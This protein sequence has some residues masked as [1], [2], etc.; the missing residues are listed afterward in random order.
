VRRATGWSLR[1]FAVTL[2]LVGAGVAAFG[3]VWIVVGC[4]RNVTA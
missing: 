1:V 4:W 2:A 3:V